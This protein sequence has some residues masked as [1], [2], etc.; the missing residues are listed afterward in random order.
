MPPARR[1]AL[2]LA[3]T[4]LAAAA[5]GAFVGPLFVQSRSGA[6]E[7][8]SASFTD[9]SGRPRRPLEWSGRVLVCNFWATWCAPCREEVP[10]LVAVR[11][12]H[13]ARGVEVLGIA[14]D[15]EAKV[16][17]FSAA[18]RVSYPVLL[19]DAGAIELMRRL[20]NAAGALP[21]TV[22]LDRSGAI[23]HRKLGPLALAELEG[24]LAGL[25]VAGLEPKM[26]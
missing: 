5:L 10:I 17:E 20:G 16:R 23:A 12:R 2:I 26:S 4:G 8:L 9:L 7:L 11:E 14:L 21:Y 3:A 18:Y 13:A 24:V 1:E 15:S 25:I 19:A 6:A 22:V